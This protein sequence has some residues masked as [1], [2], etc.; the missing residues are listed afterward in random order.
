MWEKTP[1]MNRNMVKPQGEGGSAEPVTGP[2]VRLTTLV[3][4]C[5]LEGHPGAV[6]SPHATN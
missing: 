6:L 1:D 4:V 2:C 5:A 3:K